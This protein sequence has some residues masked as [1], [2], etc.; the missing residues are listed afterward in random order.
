M[1]LVPAGYVTISEAYE[2]V[3]ATLEPRAR[4]G[5]E[6]LISLDEAA[7][8][9]AFRTAHDAEKIAER[10]F[11]DALANGRLKRWGMSNGTMVRGIV[12]EEWKPT[13]LGVPGLD[14]DFRDFTDSRDGD[15][16]R[17]YIEEKQLNQWLQTQLAARKHGAPSK[18]VS[19]V[20]SLIRREIDE[21]C[22]R[23]SQ[24]D[25]A[26]I[27]LKEHPYFGKKRAMALVKELTGNDKRGPLGPRKK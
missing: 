14:S 23:L 6:Y 13:A 24:R 20:R 15:G 5:D 17:I 16:S 26:Q 7:R 4:P 10:S 21:R 1:D 9:V 19:E 25:G 18:I 27:V 11:A 12:S 3:V 8:D 22:G 2:K